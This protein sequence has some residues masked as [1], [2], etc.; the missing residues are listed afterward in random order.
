MFLF[1]FIFIFLKIGR[2]SQVLDFI[3]TECSLNKLNLH[4]LGKSVLG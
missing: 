2:V 1:L 4:K 3:V